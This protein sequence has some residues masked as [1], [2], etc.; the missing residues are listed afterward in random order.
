MKKE[1]VERKEEFE[2]VKAAE[3][4][5]EPDR[6]GNEREKEEVEGRNLW[7]ILWPRKGLGEKDV[8]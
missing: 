7:D 1:T 4:K 2:G 3:G 8:L 6:L 5:W